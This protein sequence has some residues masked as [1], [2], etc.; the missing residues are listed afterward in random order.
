MKNFIRFFHPAEIVLIIS[1]FVSFLLKI[2]FNLRFYFP[3]PVSFS[4]IQKHYLGPLSTALFLPLLIIFITGLK[5]NFMQS[6]FKQI[7][8]LIAFAGVVFLH[9]NYKLWSQLIN[10]KTFDD[11]YLAIDK[12]LLPIISILH[13]IRESLFKYIPPQLNLYHDIFVSMFVL[14]FV[15]HSALNR[16]FDE[17]LTATTIV[18]AFGGICYSI[19]PA[20]GPFIFEQSPVLHYNIQLNMYQ[21]YK[22]FI[23]SGVTLYK[24]GYFVAALAAMPSL[25]IANAVVFTYYSIKYLKA[26]SYFYIPF[27]IYL[28]IDAIVLKWHYIIDISFGVIVAVISIVLTVLLFKI[29]YMETYI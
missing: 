21:F 27:T 26:L 8:I 10:Q 7:R 22:A 6:L 9:F 1:L 2:M 19:A 29:T 18:L 3:D 11:V 20:Y 23:Q 5:T 16:K 28:T 25:H 13:K 24:G 4:F 14:S 12:H 17:M 15:F